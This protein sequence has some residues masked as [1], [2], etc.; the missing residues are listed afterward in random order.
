MDQIEQDCNVRVITRYHFDNV[1][2]TQ[3]PED[4]EDIPRYTPVFS[5][6]WQPPEVTA[7]PVPEA[8]SRQTVQPA[9]SQANIHLKHLVYHQHR[10]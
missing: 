6:G 2:S 1:A 7:A 5:D 10:E 8:E 4:D 9:P 3:W